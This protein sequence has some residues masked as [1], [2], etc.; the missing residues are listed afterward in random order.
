MLQP[1][2]HYSIQ[3]VGLSNFQE[4]EKYAKQLN[5]SESLYIYRS[6][7][8]GKPWYILVMG[9]YPDAVTARAAK[10]KLNSQ[11]K[12]LNPWIKSFTKIQHEIKLAADSR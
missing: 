7:L 11:L 2:D 12:K 6:L 3:L 4:I 1:R 8:N 10:D 5:A 9:N